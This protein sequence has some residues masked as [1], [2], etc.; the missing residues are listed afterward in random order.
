M[1]AFQRERVCSEIAE[2]T[3]FRREDIAQKRFVTKSQTLSNHT[4]L[5]FVFQNSKFLCN[6]NETKYLKTSKFIERQS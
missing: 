1:S 2:K 4:A 3:E 6:R 5:S